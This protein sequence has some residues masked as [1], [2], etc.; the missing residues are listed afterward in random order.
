MDLQL[1]Y[2]RVQSGGR[3]PWLFSVRLEAERK[4]DVGDKISW[5]RRK[6]LGMMFEDEKRF[7]I[8]GCGTVSGEGYEMGLEPHQGPPDA[9]ECDVDV[10]AIR[11]LEDARMWLEMCEDS[12]AE[13][14]ASTS[15]LLPTRVLQVHAYDD[16]FMVKLVESTESRQ[17]GSYM[18]LSYV[19]G[20]RP[21]LCLLRSNRSAF[22]ENIACGNLPKTMQDAVRATCVL[23][24]SNLWS[25]AL[26]VVRDDDADKEIELPYMNEYYQHASAV[27][28]ASGAS[29]AHMGF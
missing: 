15:V 3:F 22:L 17:P 8:E 13:C 19:W 28:S 25:D 27:I 23:G 26:C 5:E 12:H 2:A 14:A 11:L 16:T 6:L 10:G 1:F 24:V 21:N 20:T 9:V 18:A 29:D 4:G 7:G